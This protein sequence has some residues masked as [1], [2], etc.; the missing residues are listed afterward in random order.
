MLNNINK[1]DLFYEYYT[2]WIAVYKEGAIRNVTMNKYKTIRASML[3]LTAIK[4][5]PF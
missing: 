4:P 5:E 2:Q 3:L 1:N